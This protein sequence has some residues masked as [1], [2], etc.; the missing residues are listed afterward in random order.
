LGQNFDSSRTTGPSRCDWSKSNRFVLSQNLSTVK[1]S[2]RSVCCYVG[3][4]LVCRQT[5]AANHAF[6]VIVVKNWMVYWF[7][8]TVTSCAFTNC[9]QCTVLYVCMQYTSMDCFLLLI[10]TATVSV[11]SRN[12]AMCGLAREHCRIS[13]SR[14]LAECC[15]R[16]LNRGSFVLLYFALFAL[17]SVFSLYV[18]CLS[19]SFN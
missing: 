12:C 11:S 7:C 16:R 2:S 10:Y 1:I 14:F 8:G 19:V 18:F 6:V 3:N 13:P 4:H 17:L 15:K 5:R 9:V